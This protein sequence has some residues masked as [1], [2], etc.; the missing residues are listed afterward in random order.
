MAARGKKYRSAV[1]KIGQRDPLVMAEA[2]KKIRQTAYAKFDETI[3]VDVNLG[4]DGS[5][6]DQ[7]VRGA[8]S[9]PHGLGKKV[10][11]IVFAKGNHAEEA[12]AAGADVVGA[13]DLI[14]KIEKGWLDF[15]Y[16]VAT[17]DMM[18]AVGK[19]AKI[20]GPRGL[21]P[22]KKVGTVT[23][24]VG[25]VI[26]E[27]KQGKTF[28]KNDRTGL[29]HVPIGKL[30]FA[31]NQLC[32]NY[33]AFMKALAATRPAAAKGRFLKRAT[34]SSTMGPGVAVVIEDAFKI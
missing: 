31:D 10:R 24:E 32:E 29:V 5:K 25:T 21:L 33:D 11:I 17:P 28:F 14:D 7:S 27:L 34:I 18:G 1:E 8:V 30:S 9:F 20:L 15:E 26:K 4:I 13:E 23:F 19:L 16:A 2:L 22:N 3:R 6:T 12:Q